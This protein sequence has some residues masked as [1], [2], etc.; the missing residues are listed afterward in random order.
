MRVV[1]DTREQRPWSFSEI[2]GLES[3][4]RKL[5]LGDY[6]I[7]G[8]EAR[9]CIERK[10]LDDFVKSCTKDKIR[11]WKELKAI[12]DA[13]MLACVI[14][15]AD[16]KQAYG[17][18]YTSKA[19]PSSVMGLTISIQIDMGIPV[20]WASDRVTAIRYAAQFLTAA[21]KRLAKGDD[22]L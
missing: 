19:A 18:A 3:V 7:E 1:V 13:G 2:G 21:H 12:R 22:S 16:M 20:I 11:F 10:S 6:S 5:D 4:R 17:A 15:E 14:V 8:L 9:V